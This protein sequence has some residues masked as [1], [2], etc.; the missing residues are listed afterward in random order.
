M[1]NFSLKFLGKKMSIFQHWSVSNKI[2]K[3]LHFFRFNRVNTEIIGFL[4]KWPKSMRK[5]IKWLVSWHRNCSANLFTLHLTPCQPSS[6]H[7]SKRELT[8][9]SPRGWFEFFQKLMEKKNWCYSLTPSSIAR[10]DEL[11]I[12]C[13]Q[14]KMEFSQIFLSNLS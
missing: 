11:S 3:R 14:A 5:G 8:T 4:I 10:H 7:N 9:C 2:S 1:F 13:Q 6:L 12:I